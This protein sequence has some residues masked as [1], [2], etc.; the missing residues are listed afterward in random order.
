MAVGG[1]NRFN[2]AVFAQ[3]GHGVQLMASSRRPSPPAPSPWHCCPCQGEHSM[4][5]W[6]PTCPAPQFPGP[7]FPEQ[8]LDKTF[9]E[10]YAMI[11]FQRRMFL[12]TADVR[13]HHLPILSGLTTAL[14]A[15]P[16]F[17]TFESRSMIS[18]FMEMEFTDPPFPSLSRTT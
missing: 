9:R 8:A 14:G 15:F 7:Q 4:A 13:E 16:L 6:A 5:G 2:R 10:S 11:M 1:I 12:K 18:A 17:I 3:Q